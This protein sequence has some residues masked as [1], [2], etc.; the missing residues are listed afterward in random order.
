MDLPESLVC[1]HCNTRVYRQWLLDHVQQELLGET[2]CSPCSNLV[3]T[4]TDLLC[5][6]HL[7]GHLK[8]PVV[9]ITCSR[10]GLQTG[11]VEKFVEHIQV[12]CEDDMFSSAPAQNTAASALHEQ[13]S[14]KYR[15]SYEPNSVGKEKGEGGRFKEAVGTSSQGQKMG[16]WDGQQ[17]QHMMSTLLTDRSG[18]GRQ[19]TSSEQDNG[20]H[21]KVT[22]DMVSV[23]EE[24]ETSMGLIMECE[25]IK[26]EHYPSLSVEA[27]NTPNQ[28]HFEDL[29]GVKNVKR[30]KTKVKDD[31]DKDKDLEANGKKSKTKKVNTS[32]ANTQRLQDYSNQEREDLESHMFESHGE[33][34]L[35]QQGTHKCRYCDFTSRWQ[36][37]LILHEKRHSGNYISC[38]IC[39]KDVPKSSYKSHHQRHLRTFTCPTCSKSF[40]SKVALKI[41]TDFIHEH[42]VLTCSYCDKTFRS[43]GGYMVHRHEHVSKEHP[44]KDCGM[45]FSKKSQLYTHRSKAHLPIRLKE[46]GVCGKLFDSS[47]LED[48]MKT[49]MGEE[50]KVY[51]CTQCPAS[52]KWARTLRRHQSTHEGLKTCNIC[53][54]NYHGS[55]Q[56]KRHMAVAHKEES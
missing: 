23:C 28:E 52:F 48:H 35:G 11:S 20:G 36:K 42:K 2:T 33:V 43:Y 32:E 44:C 55:R 24:D 1:S 31:W 8:T 38:E 50:A 40:P 26:E 29:S 51:K 10:C 53:N 15:V 41:H 3:Q 47:G 54:K 6:L 5:A 14:F 17:F 56:L 30:L 25:G 46:C 34:E 21:S 7:Y 49:H 45:K 13:N 18:N 37:D 39:R 4:L 22:I 19:K 27:N 12:G 16:D 9:S